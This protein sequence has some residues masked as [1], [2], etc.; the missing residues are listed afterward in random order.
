[1][2]KTIFFLS[3]IDIVVNKKVSKTPTVSNMIQ[4]NIINI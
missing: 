1:M 4:K 2:D 3:K